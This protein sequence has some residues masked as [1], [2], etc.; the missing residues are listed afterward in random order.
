MFGLGPTFMHMDADGALVG[1]STMWNPCPMTGVEIWKDNFFIITEFQT[2]N[3]KWG[4]INIY[5][6][7]NKVGRKETYGKLER[8]LV[9]MKDK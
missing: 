2:S 7:N 5:A 4:L 8:I 3:K 1:I 6:S 9:T